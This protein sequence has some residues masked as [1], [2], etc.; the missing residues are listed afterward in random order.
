MYYLISDT[1]PGKRMASRVAVPI[2][3]NVNSTNYFQSIIRKERTSY[4][5]GVLNGNVENYWGRV[6][7]ANSATY[8]FNLS[9]VDFSSATSSIVLR[10]QGLSLNNHSVGLLLNGNTLAPIQASGHENFGGNYDVPTSFLVEG[11]NSL[12]MTSL[13]GGGDFSLFDSISVSY[14]REYRADQN[15]LNFFVPTYEYT[16]LQGFGSSNIRVFETTNEVEPVQLTNLSIE[17][18][19]GQFSVNLPASEQAVMY[20]VEDS[21]I[22]QSPAVT[23]NSPST[24]ATAAHNANL[25]II[26]HADFLVQ[27]EARRS[28]ASATRRWPGSSSCVPARRRGDRR[29]LRHTARASRAAG[30]GGG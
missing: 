11:T 6:I 17:P 13:N 22:L 28:P 16:K 19:G 12:R 14:A 18:S 4:I 20:A 25:V 27:A 5:S 23:A 8:A 7:T 26:S 29:A 2:L 21:G 24:L 9:G 15:R 1:V 30:P 10:I 3:C